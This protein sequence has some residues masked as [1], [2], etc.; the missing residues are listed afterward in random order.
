M[1]DLTDNP[2]RSALA[3]KLSAETRKIL[4]EA[5]AA[6]A[7]ARQIQILTD[8]ADHA[9]R[10]DLASDTLNG[11]L[12]LLGE[13][14]LDKCR[15]LVGELNA[16]HR[17]DPNQDITLYVCS[18]GGDI[19]SGLML[20]DHLRFMSAQGHKVRT[21]ATGYCMSMAVPV[22]CAGDERLMARNT[23][24]MFHQP[25]LYA[26]GN[27]SEIADVTELGDLLYKRVLSIMAGASECT[28]AQLKNRIKRK[29]LF[30]SADEMHRM[31]F[32]EYL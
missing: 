4:V 24:F 11:V 8:E 12:W 22:W 13:I 2:I 27:L 21:I 14:D 18:E 30:V 26:E 31:K 10:R 28:A 16:K 3:D 29:D 9:R 19:M 32:G 20:Y 1:S 25:S 5:E 23:T 7:A 6:Q 15:A 17:I